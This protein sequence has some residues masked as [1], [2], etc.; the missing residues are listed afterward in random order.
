MALI[1]GP[2]TADYVNKASDSEGRCSKS[3]DRGEE[4]V[5]TVQA[6]NDTLKTVAGRSK[7]SVTRHVVLFDQF[8]I[9]DRRRNQIKCLCCRD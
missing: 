4:D 5:G 7:A 6:M 8:C 2:M 3:L 9:L 1:L